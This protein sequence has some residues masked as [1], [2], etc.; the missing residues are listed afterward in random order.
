[1]DVMHSLLTP[2][3]LAYAGVIRGRNFY[4]ERVRSA[5]HAAG[6]PVI[7]VGNVTVGGT[8]KT[9]LV[10]EVVRRLRTQG[11]RPAILPRGYRAVAGQ[12]ADEVRE[13]HESLPET[14][15]V[16]N[17]DRVAGAATARAAH[18]AD[19]VVL[20]DGFQHRRLGRDL[21]I[22]LIDALAPWGGG[23][24]LPAGRLREPLGSLRRA[25]AFVITR[26]NQVEAARVEVVCAELRRWAGDRP[27]YRAG[28]EAEGLRCA[29]G[30]L[31]PP[32]ELAGRRVLP[33]CGIGNPRTFQQV[34][35]GLTGDAEAGR[36]YPDHH[37]YE[38][39]DAL[40][41]CAAARQRGAEWVV[42]TRKDW[43]KLV[44]VWPDAGVELTRLDVRLRLLE[45]SDDFDAQLRALFGG[46][47]DRERHS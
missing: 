21:D 43:V 37:N 33:V 2:L 8:G 41:I 16:V 42:T 7:S 40:A 32:T 6:V 22:V 5:V 26:A 45:A 44:A 23:W 18:N 36:V 28:V 31:T 35:S 12:A 9:P 47:G 39:R 11:R 15:V 4:Y 46:P 34:L 27:I 14:P 38:R 30:R 20:D 17:A 1:M 3:A 19:C 10:I 24:V 29:D 13:F 25:D